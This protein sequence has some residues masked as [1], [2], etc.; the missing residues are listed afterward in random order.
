[1]TQPLLTGVRKKQT[2]LAKTVRFFDL[3]YH[4]IVRE[5]RSS[6][7][8]P[9]T[10]L[11]MAMLQ[12]IMF[13]GFFGLFMWILGR[14]GLGIRGNFMLY[15]MTGVFLFMTHVGAMA[16][17]K[18]AANPTNPMLLHSPV[19]TLLNICAASLGSLYIQILSMLVIL[20][21][22]HMILEPIEF[23][24]LPYVAL[25]FILAWFSGVAIGILFSSLGV[26]YPKQMTVISTAYSRLNMIFSGKMLA[27]NTL[28][29]TILPWFTWNPLFHAIDQARDGTFI[30][31]TAKNTNI[32]Y[33]VYVSLAIL[34]VAFMIEHLG[35]RYASK[36]WDANH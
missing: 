28:P 2:G 19:T 35:R 16:K 33:V 25:C 20:Y 36:S 9:L 4:G 26:F 30:N 5:V 6:D 3:V 17:I 34:V 10:G 1:M 21:A 29:A 14:N 15:V 31:Y 8:H 27:A 11:I 23:Y 7:R 22:V 18:A 32:E 12:S 13:I 24:N